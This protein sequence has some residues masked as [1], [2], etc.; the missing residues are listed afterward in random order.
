MGQVA[1]LLVDLQETKKSPTLILAS[2]FD[3]IHHVTIYYNGSNFNRGRAW[4]ILDK[5]HCFTA[6]CE[7]Y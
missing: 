7:P 5:I 2:S 1:N 4:V 3:T 6:L